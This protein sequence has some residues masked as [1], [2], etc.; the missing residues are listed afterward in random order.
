MPEPN[1]DLKAKQAP[2][3]YSR[4][5]IYTPL[6]I[7]VLI[8]L[9]RLISPQFGLLDDG[10]SLT[11]AQ[12]I[13]H[14][15]WDLSWDVI[16]GRARPVY[17]A[18]FA[19][20]YLLV[21]GHAFWYFL[22]NLIV[23]SATTYLLMRLVVLLGGS[24]LQAWL[25]GLIFALSTPV[26]ENVYTLSKG[27]NF[28]VLLLVGA[29]GL[30]VLAIKSA[31][32]IRFWLLI[33]SAALLMLVACFTKENTLIMLPISFVWWGISLIG[34]WKHI[35]SAQ[36]VEKIT[37]WIMLSSLVSGLLFYLGRTI[38]LSS[39]ILGVGQSSEFSFAPSQ[40][41]NSIV[42]W[43]GWIMRDYIWLLPMGVMVLVLCL[44]Q[45]RWPRSGLWWLTGVWMVF[46]LGLYL[47]WHFAL[48]YY[49]LPFAAGT[50]VLVGV[51]VVEIIDRVQQPGRIWRWMSVVALALSALLLLAT[52]ANSF[53]DA[54][55]QL[56]QDTANARVLEYVAKNAPQGSLVVVNIQ[57]A[58]EYIEQMQLMLENFY[59]RSDLELVNYQGEDLLLLKTQTH[60]TYFL[61]ADLKNQPKMTVRMGLD[62]PSLQMWNANVLPMLASWQ[63]VFQVTENPNILTIDYPRLLC[64][65][66]YRENYCSV[67][68][69]LVN[70]LPFH[71]QWTVYTP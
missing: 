24:N 64:P 34:R 16:A 53:T 2:S 51:M 23:F 36:F 7:C 19:F 45:R 10:R 62:E 39:K 59:H 38:L 44:V 25:T 68:T 54:S 46:W 49:L 56:A 32:G 65:V 8:M 9:P 33:A 50:A 12:G 5:W 42:R 15:K 6:I 57:L 11:I 14:G 29:I 48:E 41:L 22:G 47:P 28:Q 52:Q 17:W 66:I 21:G 18:A 40:I 4:Y 58:N 31:T 43:G 55:I 20:W 13:V 63:A 37:R 3:W 71:Y 61:L 70:Y 27:E 30:I 60:A 69:V 35:S 26:I 1:L 67:G